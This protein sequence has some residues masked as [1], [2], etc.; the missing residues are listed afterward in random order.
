MHVSSLTPKIGVLGDIPVSPFD[1]LLA[2]EQ[3]ET[4]YSTLLAR[5]VKRN[6]TVP[7]PMHERLRAL[8][9]DAQ[10]HPRLVRLENLANVKTSPSYMLSLS[11][12]G[13]HTIVLPIL[14]SLNRIYG[15]ISVIHFDS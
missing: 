2:I 9:L 3:M 4:A 6:S 1:N 12:G 8:T 10:E 5:P 7:S 14:R 13:D 11:L 15:P